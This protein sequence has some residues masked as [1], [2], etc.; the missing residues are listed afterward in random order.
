METYILVIYQGE[1]GP[2][3]L[4]LFGSA[5][6]SSLELSSHI[7]VFFTLCETTLHGYIKSA[8]DQSHDIWK[9]ELGKV[10]NRTFLVK[11]KFLSLRTI[12]DVLMKLTY[13]LLRKQ[14]TH[15]LRY[16][17]RTLLMKLA[18][19]SKLGRNLFLYNCQIAFIFK[20]ILFVY[21][22]SS[23]DELYIIHLYL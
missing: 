2:D 3:P 1:G 8:R 4:P 22:T 14:R 23:C 18:P 9:L 21:F 13:A 6:A 17:V 16:I 20:L 12:K 7:Y 15:N 11:R 5:H 19:G 10:K